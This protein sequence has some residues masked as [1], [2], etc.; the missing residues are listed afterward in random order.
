MFSS[1]LSFISSFRRS[2]P[3]TQPNRTSN[4]VKIDDNVSSL[5]FPIK[6]PSQTFQSSWRLFLTSCSRT[7]QQWSRRLA[8][9]PGGSWWPGIKPAPSIDTGSS[10]DDVQLKLKCWF[11]YLLAELICAGWPY[12]HHVGFALLQAETSLLAILDYLV[13]A[14]SCG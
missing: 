6:D 5:R 12:S 3:Q 11:I 1:Q 14:A 9:I 10:D 8:M 4:T 2:E 13:L 7:L